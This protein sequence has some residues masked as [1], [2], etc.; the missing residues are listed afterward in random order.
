MDQNTSEGSFGGE[1]VSRKSGMRFWEQS[2]EIYPGKGVSWL[3]RFFGL[4]ILVTVD[5]ADYNT[6]TKVV[7]EV[8]LYPE[9]TRSVAPEAAEVEDWKQWENVVGCC[10]LPRRLNSNC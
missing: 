8:V 4:T 1:M 3:R 10:E 6:T 9:G 2:H 5:F 7:H